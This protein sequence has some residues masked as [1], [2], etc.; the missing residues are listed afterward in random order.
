[1]KSSKQPISHAEI[2]SLKQ[3]VIDLISNS[4]A[5]AV[6]VLTG[7]IDASEKS[8][9]TTPTAQTQPVRIKKVG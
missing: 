6:T 1:M 2:E 7:W 9:K 5:K 3:K 4:P 8:R